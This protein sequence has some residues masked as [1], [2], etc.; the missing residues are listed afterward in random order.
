MFR[1]PTFFCYPLYNGKKWDKKKYYRHSGYIGALK[2]RTAKEQLKRSPDLILMNAVKGMLPK[3]KLG[4]KIATN[5]RVYAGPVHP[6]TAQEPEII[7]L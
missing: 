3:T 7:E 1:N 2:V 5:L 6:H 4:N